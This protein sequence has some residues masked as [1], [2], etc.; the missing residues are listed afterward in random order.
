MEHVTVDEIVP[1]FEWSGKNG[2]LVAARIVTNYNKTS[3]LNYADPG[4]EH[5]MIDH[6][7]TDTDL[8][9]GKEKEKQHGTECTP[10]GRHNKAQFVPYIITY[11]MPFVRPIVSN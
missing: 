2:L 7:I 6:S 1:Y 11:K 10:H 3:I 8:Y 5:T 4:V 9:F